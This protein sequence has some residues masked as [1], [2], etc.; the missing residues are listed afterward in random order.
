MSAAELPAPQLGR[1]LVAAGLLSEEQLAQALEDQ[2]QTGRR[3][4]EIIVQRGFISGPALANALAEQH[5]G[6]LKTEYGF[7]SGLG[8][9]VA[10]RA[11][12]ESG[13]FVSPLRPPDATS[14]PTPGNVELEDTP[15][16]PTPALRTAEADIQE[17]AP[18]RAAHEET[19]QPLAPVAF[20]PEREPE[21]EQPLQPPPLLRPAEPPPPSFDEPLGELAHP[22][23]AVSPLWAPQP[24]EPSVESEPEPPAEP[25]QDPV[26]L[27]QSEP[28]PVFQAPVA[29]LPEPEV[30][31]LLEPPIPT[32]EATEPMPKPVELRPPSPEDQH[33]VEPAHEA[34]A[35]VELYRPDVEDRRPPAREEPQPLAPATPAP[36]PTFVV[37]REP[38]P[39]PVFQVTEV[40]S[41]AAGLPL[42]D[43]EPAEEVVEL[44]EAE[45][46]LTPPAEV[47]EPVE[48][49]TQMEAPAT[50]VRDERDELIDSLRARVEAQELEL[51]N[52]R[53]Q[54]EQERG[55]KDLQV[56]VWPEEQ[57][58][59]P[60]P[61]PS[62]AEQYLLCVPTSAG[63]V[64][65]DR[66]GALPT[67][68][69]A[70]EVPEEEGNFTVTKVVRLP[71]NGRPCAYLQRA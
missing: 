14:M 51:A 2:A 67:I 15:E 66:V 57:P 40:V 13:T 38:A 50:T 35:P 17:T 52:L 71:R 10:R 12:A 33:P 44:A 37:E 9:V 6:V 7:A 1:I 61:G 65:I 32:P 48:E 19:P 11:A 54:L 64:L 69:H 68:G 56:H 55:L 70:V 53:E 41:E 49:P 46:G 4:G 45:P 27:R 47:V 25:V 43:S 60:P 36:E 5:G 18:E 62:Q 29:P 58:E 20:A 39:V 28:E 31:S 3:L 26:A 34:S 16:T 24:S 23:A 21:P 30:T 22:P 59:Q 42:Q 8:G 63:Y